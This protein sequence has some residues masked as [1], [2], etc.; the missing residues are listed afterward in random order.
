[1][2]IELLL[3]LASRP[4]VNEHKKKPCKKGDKRA[5]CRRKR[6]RYYS[7]FAVIFPR[8]M[9]TPRSGSGDMNGDG[10]GGDGSNGNGSNGGAGNGGAGG[11]SA[12]KKESLRVRPSRARVLHEM[13]KSL[14]LL[15][16]ASHDW[17]GSATVNPSWGGYSIPQLGMVK[18]R[19][20]GPVI[21]GPGFTH[22]ADGS[23]DGKGGKY[24][25]RKSPGLGFR[26]EYAWRV[27][28]KA[29]DVM[30]DEPTLTKTQIMMQ[31]MS[32]AGIMRGQIDASEARLVEMGIEWYLTDPGAVAAKRG[33]GAFGGGKPSSGAALA[34]PGAP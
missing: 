28:E 19:K 6:H 24:D 27:W 10:D 18:M 21:G 20:G 22:N 9:G 3:G 23:E 32:R 2:N 25:L 34:G 15:E 4:S 13:K 17:G 11:M 8:R 16:F 31:A 33:G 29:L 14:G 5:K 12:S 26:T 1:M 7:P 30:A